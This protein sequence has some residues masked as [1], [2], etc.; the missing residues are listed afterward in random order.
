LH[1]LSPLLQVEQV[2]VIVLSGRDPASLLAAALIGKTLAPRL[3]GAMKHAVR[4][5]ICG[6]GCHL[7]V[8]PIRSPDAHYAA[9]GVD[10]A[11]LVVNLFVHADKSASV[12]S[13]FLR[14]T[15]A[16]ATE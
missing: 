16:D 5:F 11:W 6:I 14:R 3:Q 10:L 12:R 13:W 2:E 8:D 7:D 4:R 15:F 1:G 9:F